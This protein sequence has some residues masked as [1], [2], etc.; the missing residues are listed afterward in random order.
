MICLLFFSCRKQNLEWVRLSELVR[1]K[2]KYSTAKDREPRSR[3]GPLAG[4][5]LDANMAH[6]MVA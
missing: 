5:Y 1:L 6:S 3:A 4:E 2:S